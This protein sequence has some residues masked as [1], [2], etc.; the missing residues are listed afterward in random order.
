MAYTRY[1]IKVV[2]RKN[3]LMSE[4]M[5]EQ[6]NQE[7]YSPWNLII[8]HMHVYDCQLPN[9]SC[10]ALTLKPRRTGK[11]STV[12]LRSYDWI[13]LS[14]QGYNENEGRSTS[15]FLSHDT[16]YGI[17][18]FY[19]LNLFGNST[20]PSCLKKITCIWQ[21]SATGGSKEPC[22]TSQGLPYL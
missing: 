21:D 17:Y 7:H 6:L 14:S 13:W 1:L 22:E 5:N 11:V 8:L 18:S 4:W 10:Q 15:F 9:I 12:C 3:E 19:L 2:G 20:L 16:K